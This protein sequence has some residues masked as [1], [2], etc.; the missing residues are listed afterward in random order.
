MVPD[1]R[2]S[3]GNTPPVSAAVTACLPFPV[4]IRTYTRSPSLPLAYKVAQIQHDKT[5]VVLLNI[6]LRSLVT[7]GA[8]EDETKS[9]VLSFVALNSSPSSRLLPSETTLRQLIRGVEKRSYPFRRAT[10]IVTW[11]GTNFGLPSR[12]GTK[13]RITLGDTP[14]NATI[15]RAYYNARV[16]SSIALM[17]LRIA[18]AA[19]NN[20]ASTSTATS[21]SVTPESESVEA[22][23]LA[24]GQ[25][26]AMLRQQVMRWWSALDKSDG[27][28]DTP[29]ARKVGKQAVLHGLIEWPPREES[30]VDGVSK[31]L[32]IEVGKGIKGEE[33]KGETELMAEV[34]GDLE[35]GVKEA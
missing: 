28:W 14:G 24:E 8:N 34:K 9:F 16:P 7:H 2:L 6:V 20:S 10:Q 22:P 11:F 18:I 12:D 17:L 4:G 27:F 21:V 25:V 30:P 15:A 3:K 32:E 19:A 31:D 23:S 5:A 29:E 35:L 26:G 13:D 33:I 1:G